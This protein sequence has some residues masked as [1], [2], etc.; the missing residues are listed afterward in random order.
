MAPVEAMAPPEILATAMVA[1]VC[2]ALFAGYPVALTLAGVSLGFAGIG[3]LSGAMNFALIGALP[4]RMFGVM[5]NEVLLAIPLFI[6]MGVMLERSQ[7]A[8][9]LLETMGRLFGTLPG[10]LGISVLLVGVL[11]AAAKGV[12]GA[13][14]VT[15]GLIMLPSML[16]HGY[17]P[18]LASG[19]VAATATL[20]QIFPPATV[21]VLLGD[22]MSNAYQSAQLSQGIFAPLSVTVSDLFAGAIIPGLALVAFYLLYLIAVAVFR[23]QASPALP[24]DQGGPRGV[25]LAL[26]LV[27]VLVAPVLLILAVIGSILGGMATPTEAASVGAVGA[28]ILTALK[29]DRSA[30]R[31]VFVPVVAR[32][33]Q[34]TSMIFLIL[35]GA[36]MFSLVFRALGGDDMV[37]RGLTE[38]PG[39]TTSAIL[40]VMIAVFLLGF[41]M[42]AFE[43]I[44]VVVPIVA[45]ALLMMPGIDPVWLAI[46]LAMN[47][48]TSYMHPPLGPTL[49]FLRGVAPPEITTMHIYVGIIPFVLIQLFALIVLWFA[50]GLATWLPHRLYGP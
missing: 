11:L 41:V 7:I 21:L 49:F 3:H 45:P 27:R 10:G 15:I 47:L 28:I 40:I 14:T 44:F 43:I 48:Q 2:I 16:R 4:Q 6:F 34:V 42:D 25:I 18:R 22:Q 13:T 26:R 32:T 30:L 1:A 37:Q 19:T 17:D 9:E 8:E 31:R 33:T 46:M 12:V 20:A 24:V 38:L 23:P 35:I 36:T 39:G 29:L 50:P 5:S